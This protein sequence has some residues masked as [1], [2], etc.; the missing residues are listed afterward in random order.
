ME[1]VMQ[2][3]QQ[4]QQPIIIIISIQDVVKFGFS[5]REYVMLHE[6]SKDAEEDDEG[7]EN[8]D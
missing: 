1:K 2:Q 7:E 8:P 4:Q 6:N 3:Q 5:S